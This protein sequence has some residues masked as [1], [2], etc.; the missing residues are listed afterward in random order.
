M[1]KEKKKVSPWKEE[2]RGRGGLG[3]GH[4]LQGG[5]NTGGGG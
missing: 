3:N 4:Q 2:G 1:N 5:Y